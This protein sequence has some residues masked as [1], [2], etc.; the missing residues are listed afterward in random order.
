MAGNRRKRRR[1]PSTAA[2]LEGRVIAAAMD[3]AEQQILDG[4][5]SAQVITHFVKQGSVRAQIEAEKLHQENLLLE[6][7]I[8][9]MQSTQRMEELYANAIDAMRGYSGEPPQSVE[10]EYEQ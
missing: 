6:A 8:A 7:K 4:T 10:G 1:P 3:L 2:G 9:N 5:A